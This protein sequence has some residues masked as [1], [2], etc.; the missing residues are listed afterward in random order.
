M[1][2]FIFIRITDYLNSHSDLLKVAASMKGYNETA[3]LA[4][5]RPDDLLRNALVPHH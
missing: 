2:E 4:K 1:L 3:A 5:R